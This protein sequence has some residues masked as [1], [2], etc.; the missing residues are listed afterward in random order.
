MTSTP[1]GP[2]S[3]KKNSMSENNTAPFRVPVDWSRIASLSQNQV[4]EPPVF[5]DTF[6]TETQV[7]NVLVLDYTEVSVLGA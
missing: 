5:G 4:G 2:T 3:D 1:L 6:H 7:K